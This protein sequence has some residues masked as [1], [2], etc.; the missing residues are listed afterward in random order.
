MESKLTTP[1]KK[2][3]VFNKYFQLQSQ[4]GDNNKPV[5]NLPHSANLLSSIIVR[6]E[7]VCIILKAFDTGKAC[8]PDQIS[9][10][11]LKDVA[12]AISEPL[13]DLFN[14]G[15]SLSS[16]PDIWKKAKVFPIHKKVDTTLVENYRPIS[17]LSSLGKTLEKVVHKNM[18]NFLIENNVITPF[19]SGFVP[20]DSTVNQLVDLYNPLSWALDEG[21]EVRVVFCDISKAFDRVWHKGLVVKLK[22]Y[23]ISGG[24]LS[25]FESYLLNRFQRVVLPEGKSEWLEIKAGVP[26]GS[27]LGPLLFIL[28]INDIVHEIH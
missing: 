28:Y 11:V 18:H 20:G 4:L 12:E 24:L 10:R 1:L 17:L 23:G 13:T 21:K 19:Q 2:T 5:Q 14:S 8:G 6:R 9:N 25:W 3:N 7:E 22:H 15:L 16:V 27:I 26:Q